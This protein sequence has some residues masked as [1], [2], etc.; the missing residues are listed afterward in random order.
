MREIDS[1][2][3]RLIDIVLFAFVGFCHVVNGL[4]GEGDVSVRGIGDKNSIEALKR[5]L[6]MV[7]AISNHW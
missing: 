1:C 5:I 7:L 3:F 6:D 2:T 4:K